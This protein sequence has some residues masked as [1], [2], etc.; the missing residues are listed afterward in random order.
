MNSP[1]EPGSP[2]ISTPSS[3]SPPPDEI[4]PQSSNASRLMDLASHITASFSSSSKR[5]LPGGSSFGASAS[6]RDH[7]TR[8]RGD[9]GRNQATGGSAG[10]WDGLKEGKKEK[11]ENLIDSHIVEHLRKE[12]GDPFQD[13][14]LQRYS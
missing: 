9:S 7:K 13:T 2:S 4:N 5:R 6:N 8:R 14:G 3:G 12:I 1:P 10:N 11:D